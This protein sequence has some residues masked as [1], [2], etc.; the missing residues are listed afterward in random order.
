MGGTGIWEGWGVG[1]AECWWDWR[2]GQAPYRST[3]QVN[4][5]GL[6]VKSVCPPEIWQ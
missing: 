6:V 2:E 4:N 1:G 5:G 3:G